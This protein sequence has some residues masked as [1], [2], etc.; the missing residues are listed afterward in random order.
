MEKRYIASKNYVLRKIAGKYVLVSVGE[1]I[2]DF[3][4][5]VTLNESAGVLWKALQQGAA[6]E[7]LVKVLQETFSITE[8]QAK[9]DVEKSLQLLLEHRMIAHE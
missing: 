8:E 3:C 6:E 7:E 2:A 9:E 5:V 4:G 1:G